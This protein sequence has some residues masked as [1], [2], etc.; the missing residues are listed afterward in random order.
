[1][2]ST[3]SPASLAKLP[4]IGVG[5]NVL[6]AATKVAGGVFGNSYALVADGIES[7]ADIVT[8]LVVWAGLRVAERPP[9][10]A[11]PYGYGKA[12]AL[13]GAMS[14]LALLAAAVTIAVQSIE[15]IREPQHSPHWSTLLILLLVI[16]AKFSLAWWIGREG[17]SVGSTA[18]EGDA[19]HHGSDA[20]TSAAALIGISI[21]LIGGPGYEPADDWAALAACFVIAYSGVRLLRLSFRD[22]LDA[23]PSP[24][25]VEQ[26]RQAALA[27]PGVCGIDKVRIRKS[28]TTHYV[29][30][31]VQ[32]DAAASVRTGHDIGGAVRGTLRN[33][34]L[35]IADVLVHIEPHDE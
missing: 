11:H 22:V 12:E 2:A 33:S 28:G 14:G 16:G 15:Q 4:L 8:S 23:A 7:T 19:W 9:N 6:L 10:E 5:V 13:A 34:P 29:D 24:E 1:M 17:R 26:V 35:R 20:L 18:L 30:I 32:V 31:H 25:F 27:V 21:G 3:D